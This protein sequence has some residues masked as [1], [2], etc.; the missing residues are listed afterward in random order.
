M[1]D[2]IIDK[3]GFTILLGLVAL[4]TAAVAAIFSVYG[5]ATLFAGAF[6]SVAI[7][8]GVLEVAKII[9]VVYLYR[10]WKKTTTWLAAYITI[11]VLVLM[12]ITS[13]GIFGFLSSA[14]QKSSTEFKAQEQRIVLVENTRIYAQDRI[15]QAQNRI[16]LLNEMRR[17]QESR[18]SEALNNIAISRNPIALKQIQDQT[19]EMITSTES[20]IQ[21][22]Q[23]K[24]ETAI[25]EIQD[26]DQ[27][28]N[29]LRFSK[30]F[31]DIRTFQFVAQLFNT[32]L[33]IIAKW[34]I[35]AL[36]LVF[37]PLAIALILAYN[38]IVF[39]R[40]TSSTKEEIEEPI[41]KK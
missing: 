26:I 17:S 8:A 11:A 16:E 10:Y 29:E 19:A 36:I 37:D 32:E 1:K 4:T 38:V 34:F 14:Y 24:I 5:I 7:M 23:G 18:L 30:D 41:K 39:G 28:V 25:L 3:I 9:S 20:D 21:S 40:Y 27:R 31:T 2:Y 13:L 22:E 33:D 12:L 35:F 6:I 15:V